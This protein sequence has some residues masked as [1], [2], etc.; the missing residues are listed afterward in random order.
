MNIYS[1][2][3]TKQA[4]LT[5]QRKTTSHSSRNFDENL[6][7]TRNSSAYK[8]ILD[9][10]QLKP[11]GTNS[12]LPENQKENKNSSPNEKDLSYLAIYK[13]EKQKLLNQIKSWE[14]NEAIPTIAAWINIIELTADLH[15]KYPVRELFNRIL[16]TMFLLQDYLWHIALEK[17]LFYTQNLYPKFFPDLREIYQPI[18]YPG[19]SYTQSVTCYSFNPKSFWLKKLSLDD[20]NKIFINCF[21][22][23]CNTQILPNE[24][25]KQWFNP[26]LSKQANNLVSLINWWHELDQEPHVIL[27]LK[28]KEYLPDK[29]ALVIDHFA[30]QFGWFNPILDNG[31][32]MFCPIF[33]ECINHLNHLPSHKKKGLICAIIKLQIR[34]AFDIYGST[35]FYKEIIRYAEQFP[36][37]ENICIGH[38]LFDLVV[39]TNK[40][41]HFLETIGCLLKYVQNTQVYV[42]N[43]LF[44][45]IPLQ[46]ACEFNQLIVKLV[47]YSDTQIY[48]DSGSDSDSSCKE[49][50]YLEILNIINKLSL[51]S[52]MTIVKA[53]I[54]Y[55]VNLPKA[56]YKQNKDGADNKEMEPKAQGELEPNAKHEIPFA[57]Q[58][59]ITNEMSL[60]FNELEIIKSRLAYRLIIECHSKLLPN[61]RRQ[62]KTYFEQ[63]DNQIDEENERKILKTIQV[64]IFK[65][66]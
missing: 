10:N 54:D 4:N 59:K 8:K 15:K 37:L 30:N 45:K 36:P 21:P 3:V 52:K 33:L 66:M 29:L 35:T 56:C 51:A 46:L 53:M 6:K 50:I 1:S 34:H 17:F 63:L 16:Y 11:V 41:K 2:Q 47:K 19:F 24:Y 27:G 62:L 12:N 38:T 55:L 39:V 7:D 57:M 48:L 14:N 64:A 25:Y 9:N 58:K 13:D 5:S 26:G 28:K 61:F 40:E 32:K 44:R 49:K 42:K 31:N 22:Q 18:S 23:L 43:E 20:L 60:G 65:N